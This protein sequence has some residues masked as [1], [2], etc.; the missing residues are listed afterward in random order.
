M[1]IARK[2]AHLYNEEARMLLV[3][4]GDADSE[5]TERLLTQAHTWMMLSGDSANAS[6]V[7]LNLSEFHARRAEQFA[8]AKDG[9]APAP[10]SEEQYSLWLK[11]IECC[12]EAVRLSDKELGR[13]EGA[14]AHLRVGVH[15]STRIPMQVVLEGSKR[16]EMLSELADKHLGKALR[17]FD[18]LHDEREIAVCHFH[19]ADLF[20]QERRV[21]GDAVLPK[22][23]LTSAL[24]HAQRSAEYWTRKG[25]LEYAKDFIASHV[26]IARLLECQQKHTAI[27]DA[28]AHLAE[29]EQE[30]LK[31]AKTGSAMGQPPE[32]K[33]L[34]IMVGSDSVAVAP[35]RREMSRAC[36][37]GLRQGADVER[38][39]HLYRRVL[40]NEPIDVG[41]R[42]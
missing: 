26:R 18:E 11:A 23:R 38:L 28:I 36:Q 3:R 19:M 17:A 40:R 10:L 9:D 13:R 27:A 7:L 39:K 24:R 30:L 14:F 42:P 5:E 1:K 16:S 21:L 6:R 15:L 32:E 12:E 31:L 33:E 22:S 2:L 41:E 37:A 29:V 8:S 35:F 34:F 4:S 20:L 25:A